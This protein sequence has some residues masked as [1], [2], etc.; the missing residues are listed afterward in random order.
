MQCKEK[1]ENA[2]TAIEGLVEGTKA[3]S[4]S[5]V[6]IIRK[7]RGRIFADIKRASIRRTSVYLAALFWLPVSF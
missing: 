4:K 6:L 1:E 2:L 3:A 5:L 7:G